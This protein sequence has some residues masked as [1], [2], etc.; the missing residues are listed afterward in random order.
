MK[1]V[2]VIYWSGTG[3][4]KLMA[5]A[6]AEGAKDKGCEVKLINVEDA[7]KEDV[8][9]AD[10]LALGC[11]SMGAEV[12]EE[13]TMEPFVEEIAGTVSGKKLALFG[14]YDWGDGQWMRD[15][16]ERMEGYGAQVV[17]GEGYIAHLTPDGDALDDCR[18]LGVKLA[19]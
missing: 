18:D 6:V 9:S 5:E 10:A 11:P 14:S 13:Y 7:T 3:N 17:N 2:S 16:T 1:N 19:E 4:T 15:W 8:S 12:L